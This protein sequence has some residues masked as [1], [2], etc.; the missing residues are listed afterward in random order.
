MPYTWGW[1]RLASFCNPLTEMPKLYEL[2]A[3]LTDLVDQ[4]KYE[5]WL[6]RKAAAHVKRDR[7]RKDHP[8]TGANYRRLIH[9]AV[10]ASAGL[11]HY[12]GDQLSWDKIS[13]YSNVD[14]KAQRSLYKASLALLPTVDHVL[15]EDG[16]YDFVICGWRTNDAKNDL[17]HADF[18]AL[19]RSVIDHHD[20]PL[21]D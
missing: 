14:S 2:P 1:Q 4:P 11:D 20:R 16:T 9:A 3:F 13:T 21:P 12:T 8:I 7:L 10:N 19:C 5:K 15:M 17:S 6:H 18:I